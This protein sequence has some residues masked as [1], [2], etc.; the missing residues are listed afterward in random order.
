VRVAARV[1]GQARARRGRRLIEAVDR[2]A[3][4]GIGERRRVEIVG[5]R[6]ARDPAGGVVGERGAHIVCGTREIMGKHRQPRHRIGR[7]GGHRAVAPRQRRAPTQIV[8]AERRQH[9]DPRGRAVLAD[10][11]QVLRIV[12]IIGDVERVRPGQ[13]RAVPRR[14]ILHA[15]RTERATLAG[16]PAQRVIAERQRL[17]AGRSTGETVQQ[18]MAIA[19]RKLAVRQRLRGQLVAM[20]IAIGDAGAVTQPQRRDVALRIVARRLVIGGRAARS[21]GERIGR[22][23]HPIEPVIAVGRQVAVRIAKRNASDEATATQLG[24]A[25][26]ELGFLKFLCIKA[27]TLNI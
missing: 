17:R 11:Q 20:I 3:L 15:Q 25:S 24:V 13:P 14:I 6:G 7:G 23:D 2:I 21:R 26:P 4:R 8:I 19:H 1:I 27:L 9:A 5:A 18:I 22:L 16:H 12:V 10:V